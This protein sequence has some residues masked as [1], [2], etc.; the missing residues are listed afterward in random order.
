MDKDIELSS[1]PTHQVDIE[2]GRILLSSTNKYVTRKLMIIM[3]IEI[4]ISV[5]IYINYDSLLDINLLLAP[6]LLGALTAALAQTFNQFVKNTY[7]FEK[8]IKF[9]VWGIINGLLT[10]MWIDIIMSIDDFYLRVFIDQSIG[11]PGFQLIFT[12]LNSLWDNGSLNKSTINA[13]FKSLKY[14]YCYWP[15]VSILVFGFL[16]LD[17]IFPCNC[18][19][20]LIW[21][22]ILSRLA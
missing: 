7:S 1:L 5:Y 18:A 3:I 11:A 17:I 9:I 14:S 2:K 6:S 20:A 12:I 15:F 21:N 16:P 22:I 8:I 10:A 13:F 19:A 4:F